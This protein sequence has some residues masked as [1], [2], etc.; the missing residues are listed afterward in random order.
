MAHA[1]SE[2]GAQRPAKSATDEELQPKPF[3]NEP[4]EVNPLAG[5]YAPSSGFVRPSLSVQFLSQAWAYGALQRA[6]IIVLFSR[7]D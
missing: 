2:L 3:Q 7:R 5:R 4:F 1:K 6:G